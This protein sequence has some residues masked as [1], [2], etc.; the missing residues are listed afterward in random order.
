MKALEIS[1]SELEPKVD[2]FENYLYDLSHG[3][4]T[5][6]EYDSY[7]RENPLPKVPPDLI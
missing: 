6:N 5:S 3:L 4:V 2:E 1:K 7:Y